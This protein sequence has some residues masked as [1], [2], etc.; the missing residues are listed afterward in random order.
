MQEYKSKQEERAVI[1][2]MKIQL[3]RDAQDKHKSERKALASRDKRDSDCANNRHERRVARRRE[4]QEERKA[5]KTVRD[6]FT[7]PTLVSV[8]DHPIPKPIKFTVLPEPPVLV[9]VDNKVVV[10]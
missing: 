8:N 10:S 4:R 9:L 5:R 1:D 3:E 7:G 6:Y 2:E